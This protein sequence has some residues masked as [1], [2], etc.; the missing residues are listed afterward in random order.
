MSDEDAQPLTDE[1]ADAG[2][3]AADGLMARMR[4]NAGPADGWR[5]GWLKLKV[6]KKADGTYWK[7]KARLVVRGFMQRVGLDFYTT[8]SPMSTLNSCRI[9]LAT[10]IKHRIPC[11]HI[12]IPNAFIQEHAERDLYIELPKGLVLSQAIQQ[13]VK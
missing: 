10:A 1:V 11:K 6:K 5:Q 4:L 12:D 9:V 2:P 7:H 8:F 13:D 3:T